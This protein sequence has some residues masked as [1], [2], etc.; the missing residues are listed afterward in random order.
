M[1]EGKMESGYL[2]GFGRKL[3]YNGEC[4]YGN[5]E[6]KEVKVNNFVSV[7]SDKWSWYLFKGL[8]KVTDERIYLVN[9]H[10]KV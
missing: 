2:H 1:I 9:K 4:Q 8:G 3:T 7:A 10:K 6:K 5:W